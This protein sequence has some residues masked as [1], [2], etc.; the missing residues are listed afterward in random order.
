MSSKLNILAIYTLE[1]KEAVVRLAEFFRESTNTSFWH[2]CSVNS[3]EEWN[4]QTKSQFNKT[5]VYLLMVSNTFMHSE[6]VQRIEFKNVIDRYKENKSTVIPILIDKC[7]WNVDFNSDDY[8][9]NMQ[10]LQVLPEG[11]KPIHHWASQEEGYQNVI[12]N[13]ERVIASLTGEEFQIQTKVKEK[14][15]P[16]N[17]K[18]DDQ[19]TLDFNQKEIEQNLKLEEEAKAKLAKEEIQKKQEEVKHKAAAEQRRI[20]KVANEQKRKEE[21]RVKEEAQIKKT[22]EE[23][24]SKADAEAKRQLVERNQQ[25]EEKIRN[26]AQANKINSEAQPEEAVNSK[27]R[28]V[29]GL[30]LS[31]ITII[32]IW[33]FSEFTGATSEDSAIP[34]KAEV[35]QI[36]D[37]VALDTAQSNVPHIEKEA[38]TKLEIGDQYKGG[39]IFSISNSGEKGILAHLDDAGPMSWKNAMNIHEQLGEGWRLP[40]FEELKMMYNTIGNGAANSGEFADKLYWSATDYDEYQARLIRFSDGNTSYHYNKMAAHRQFH[41]RAVQDFNR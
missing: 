12:F 18:L 29:L 35:P 7:P 37:S 34:A 4:L 11:Q 25:E 26:R 31:F 10:E 22:A 20:E 24:K 3:M 27:R 17:L 6:F 1:D 14:D 15:S 39:I 5:D 38:I 13:L 33:M 21:L 23:N 36:I 2:K 9:F 8:N 19:I 41:V 40:T 32:G 28:I 30:L 16:E